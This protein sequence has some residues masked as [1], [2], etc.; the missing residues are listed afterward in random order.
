MTNWPYPAPKD[1]GGAAHLAPGTVLPDIALIASTG[2]MV[3]LAKVAGLSV[4]FVYPWTGR[5]GLNN[6]P[7]WDD[8]PGAHGSSPEA[9][10]FRDL[11]ADY[12]ARGV[13]VFGL[14]TQTREWQREFASRAGLTFPLLSDAGFQVANALRLPRFSA[15]GVTYLK[16]LTLL[17]WDGLIVRTIYPVHPPDTHAA[18]LLAQL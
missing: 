5:P 14:S 16:R 11:S 18:D 17:C 1:D 15:G 4:V 8:I 13:Q 3:S 10:G 7:G 6:P 12:R 9:D 2:E